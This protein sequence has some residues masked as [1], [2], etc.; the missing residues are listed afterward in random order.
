MTRASGITLMV[1]ALVFSAL[2]GPGH[3]ADPTI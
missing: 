2:A 1:R 3:A